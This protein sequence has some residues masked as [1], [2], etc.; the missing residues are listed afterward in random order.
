[1]YFIRTSN[2]NFIYC[3]KNVK[4]KGRL[5]GLNTDI[6]KNKLFIPFIYESFHKVA[7]FFSPYDTDNLQALAS[8]A[9]TNK[10]TDNFKLCK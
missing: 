1:M 3:D 6:P 5:P 10:I 4:L 9:N 2:T 7:V 8:I